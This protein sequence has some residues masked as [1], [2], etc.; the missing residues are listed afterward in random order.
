MASLTV[1]ERMRGR[2]TGVQ[3]KPVSNRDGAGL[4][5]VDDFWDAETVGGRSTVAPSMTSVRTPQRKTASVG[6]A[7]PAIST[8]GFDFDVS[9]NENQK[10]PTRSRKSVGRKSIAA[11]VGGLSEVETPESGGNFDVAEPLSDISMNKP[12]SRSKR[13]SMSMGGLSDAESV[14]NF[15]TG[16]ADYSEAES[17]VAPDTPL[18]V[19]KAR[20]KAKEDNRKK[21]QAKKRETERKKAEKRAFRQNNPDYQDLDDEEFIPKVGEEGAQMTFTMINAHNTV[22]DNEESPADT[23][24]RRSKRAKFAPLK[25]WKNEKLV[26]KPD[27]DLDDEDVLDSSKT[28]L[29]KIVGVLHA[30][31]TPQKKKRSNRGGGGRKGPKSLPKFNEA[32]LN[33]AY[34]YS[35]EDKAIVWDEAE[36][37]YKNSKI[38]SY[39]SSM[40]AT[41]LPITAEREAG[42]E[43]VGLA[44][45]AFNINQA[46]EDVPGWISGHVILPAEGIKDAEGVGMCSQV[47][48]VSECQPKAF[49]VAIGAPE[50]TVFNPATAQRFLLS[51]GDFFH[52]PP[53]NIYR[54]ENHSTE[55]EC[56]LFWTIIRPMQTKDED[57][58]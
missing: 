1:S 26:V 28:S 18:E 13:M 5:D 56:K 3:V 31:P 11:S 14:T 45:Q 47:F 37:E 48:F 10:T 19:K 57:E 35:A 16:D 2:R 50:E 24:V 15:E 12:A 7:S 38:I 27:V 34:T 42:K 30:L 41:A 52:V 49:E 44:A 55:A 36:G 32:E 4:E 22:T 6:S 39:A 25:F 23:E 43:A 9:D 51:A 21:A 17:S 54:V 20:A 33:D 46:T 29:T 8:P 53:N 58:A 40:T